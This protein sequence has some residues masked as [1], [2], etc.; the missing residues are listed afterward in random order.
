MILA[1]RSFLTGLAGTVICAPAIVRASSL[2]AIKAI[3]QPDVWQLTE[4]GPNNI[5]MRYRLKIELPQ[6]IPGMLEARWVRFDPR[7]DKADPLDII[8]QAS[9]REIFN[10]NSD[11]A[12]AT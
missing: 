8:V 11:L 6:T 12:M 7:K 10:H 4:L 3:P 5:I 9:E 1:R 2:M